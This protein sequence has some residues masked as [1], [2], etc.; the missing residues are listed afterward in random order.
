MTSPTARLPEP[1]LS[2]LEGRTIVV[3]GAN[4]GIGRI[5]ARSLAAA[6]ARVIL[7][8]R[9]P[10][11]GLD[12]AATMTGDV[13][14]RT[15][16]LADLASIR[17]FADELSEPIDVLINNAG[18]MIPPLGRTAD[19]FEL[20]F[21]TN[22]LGHFAL[23]NLLLPR[24]RD[25]VVTLAS[26]G[27]RLG[28]I[29]LGDLN[30]ERRPYRA[31]PAYAQSKLANLLFTAELHRRLAAADSP[32]RALAAH[33][34]VSSTNLLSRNQKLSP[35][36]RL[37]I[38]WAQPE[39]DGAQPTLLAASA[40]LPGNS[41]IGPGEFM[42]WR[43]APTPASRSRRARDAQ[44]ARRL[45]VASEELTGESFPQDAMAPSS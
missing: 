26:L 18:L 23:T 8:V 14:V 36:E 10:Q 33:P 25:R 39:E 19:G 13:E 17:S 30:W 22:H 15:L 21:G 40:D 27:H 24:I 34:G 16:D 32:V 12:A 37:T 2:A 43:G 3:T 38:R 45:W 11:K 28:R 6:G 35:V 5:A 1:D 29:D 44:V 42:G 20:Q 7:A 31:L 41:Y 9:T 4:S